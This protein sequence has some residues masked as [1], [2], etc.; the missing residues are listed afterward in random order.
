MISSMIRSPVVA[1]TSSTAARRLISSSMPSQAAV[2]I[3][4]HTATAAASSA[5]SRS[6]KSVALA[7]GGTATV[8]G[9]A[10]LLFKDEVVYWTPNARK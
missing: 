5:A 9:G 3:E 10:S 4:H 1:K 6:V 8:I 2:S 7:V